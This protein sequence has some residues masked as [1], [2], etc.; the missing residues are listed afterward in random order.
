MGSIAASWVISPFMGGVIAALFLAFIKMAI[1]YQDDKIAAAR[2]WVPVLIAIMAGAFAAYLSIKALKAL[3]DIS[4]AQALDDRRRNRNSQ[5]GRRPPGDSP[6]NPRASKTGT[7]SLRKL[8]GIPPICSAALLSFAH[9]ANDVAN[10]SA[11]W[12]RLSTPPD[13]AMWRPR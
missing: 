1:I 6:G 11:P 10:A 3:I 5:L 9:G 7:Q 4:L 2:R 8:F 12:P 13:M